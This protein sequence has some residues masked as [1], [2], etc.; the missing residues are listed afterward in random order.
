MQ[1]IQNGQSSGSCVFDVLFLKWP[2]RTN[3]QRDRHSLLRI[4][5]LC[6]RCKLEYFKVGLKFRLRQ[7]RNK[8]KWKCHRSKTT[9]CLAVFWNAKDLPIRANQTRNELKTENEIEPK[10]GIKLHSFQQFT[11]RH[12]RQIMFIYRMWSEM[13]CLLQY[14][15]LQFCWKDF[16]FNLLSRRNHLTRAS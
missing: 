13:P 1:W 9:L 7:R 11:Q 4:R 10:K 12:Q 8:S 16:F 6:I 15:S 14:L 5:F 2:T 3:T